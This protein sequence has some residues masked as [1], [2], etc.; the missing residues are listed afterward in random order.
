MRGHST[1]KDIEV[2]VMTTGKAQG[3]K[4]S[5]AEGCVPEKGWGGKGCRGRRGKKVK[6]SWK[7]LLFQEMA[8]IGREQSTERWPFPSFMLQEPWAASAGRAAPCSAPRCPA[9]LRSAAGQNPPSAA[10]SEPTVLMHAALAQRRAG[11]KNWRYRIRGGKDALISPPK[12]I[13]LAL[14]TVKGMK[15]DVWSISNF[16]FLIKVKTHIEMIHG[17]TE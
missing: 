12:H 15:M 5:G 10:S 3:R 7:S 1:I 16:P 9:G 2:F 17:I 13:S 8:Q 6:E 11:K 4:E 14:I